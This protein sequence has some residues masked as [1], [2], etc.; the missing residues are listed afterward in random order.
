[1]TDS[2]HCHFT[3]HARRVTD[4]E[5]CARVIFVFLTAVV[6]FWRFDSVYVCLQVPTFRR[7]ILPEA[8]GSSETTA[9]VNESPDHIHTK[10]EAVKCDHFRIDVAING[11][12][13]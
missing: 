2:I 13:L 3:T 4:H 1:V 10:C 6:V 11:V 8:A 5:A 12:E 7:K 9:V